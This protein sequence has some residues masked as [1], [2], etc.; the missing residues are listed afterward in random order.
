[1]SMYMGNYI[2]AFRE[3]T[4]LISGTHDHASFYKQVLKIC[5]IKIRLIIAEDKTYISH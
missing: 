3:Y 1:M 2:M 4:S 5:T